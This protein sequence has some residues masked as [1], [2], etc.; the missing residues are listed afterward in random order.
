MLA[1]IPRLKAEYAK[2]STQFKKIARFA[3]NDTNVMAEPFHGNP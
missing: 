1:V 3:R 2:S